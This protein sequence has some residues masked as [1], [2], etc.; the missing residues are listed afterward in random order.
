ML[1]ELDKE[2]AKRGHKFVRYAD[3]MVIFC[4]SKASAEQTLTHIIPY[5]EKKLFLRVNQ[6]KTTIA[7]GTGIKFLGYGFY[8]TG[9]GHRM[10]VHPKTRKKMR[11]RVKELTSRRKVNDYKGWKK[12]M[13]EYIRGW[14]NYYQLADMKKSLEAVDQWMRR[15]IRMVFWKKWKEPKTRYKN[16]RKLGLGHDDA[17]KSAYCHRGYWW[18]AH[19]GTVQRALSN[20]RLIREGFLFFSPYYRSVKA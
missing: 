3:D 6:E 8:K 7:K 15:R 14:I 18:S 4:R 13:A 20:E 2:L 19:S 9:N 16:L 5:I 17:Y 12:S 11:K 1:N 10:M